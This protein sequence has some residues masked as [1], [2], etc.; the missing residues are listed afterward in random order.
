MKT[1]FDCHM[2]K[3]IDQFEFIKN[4]QCYRRI[5]RSCLYTKRR[6]ADTPTKAR[7]RQ[8]KYSSQK[9]NIPTELT[10]NEFISLFQGDCHYCGETAP[11]KLNGIDRINSNLGYTQSNTVSCCWR[12]NRAKNDTPYDEFIEWISS[13]HNHLCTAKAQGIAP[14]LI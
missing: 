14:S 6:S 4:S 12:C 9:H 3:P 5:C 8:Y 10:E 2:T 1:C 11:A 7:L 13:V